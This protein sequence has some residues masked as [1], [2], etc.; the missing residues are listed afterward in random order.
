VTYRVCFVCSGNICRSPMAEVVLRHKARA[1]G[2]SAQIEVD[3][4][5]TTV[6]G[7]FDM[8]PRARQALEARGYEAPRHHSRQFEPVWLP[9]RDLVLAMDHGHVRWLERHAPSHT[10]TTRIRLLLSFVNSP[11]TPGGPAEVE[12]PYY[13]DAA[14]FENCLELIEVGCAAV[15]EVIARELAAS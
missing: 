8:D 10:D 6:A 15:L 13:G 14:D 12:D 7:G 11:A 4:A 9:Q 3:S 1:V 5:G 2:L